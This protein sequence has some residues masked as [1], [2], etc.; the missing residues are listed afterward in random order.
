MA[1]QLTR[2][3]GKQVQGPCAALSRRDHTDKG[4]QF[5]LTLAILL[6][7]LYRLEMIVSSQ[8]NQI[9]DE[10]REH[11]ALFCAIKMAQSNGFKT[12]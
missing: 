12:K 1:G 2:H 4:I 5:Q 9:E 3:N 10:G 11:E 8:T 7:P 6:N